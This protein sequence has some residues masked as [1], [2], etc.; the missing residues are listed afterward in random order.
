MIASMEA[1][2]TLLPLLTS[3]GDDRADTI[4]SG[5]ITLWER[6][7]PERIRGYY[8]NGSYANATATP[9]SDLDL[10]I[11]FKGRY[12][13]QAESDLAQELCESIEALHPATFVDM[14]YLTEDSLQQPDRVSIALQLKR[15]SCL[16]YGED[17]RDQISASPD[18]RYVRDTMHIPYFGSRYGR[19]QLEV[20]TFPLDYPD[21]NG[22]FYGYDGWTL[23]SADDREQP[24][25]KMLV[26]IVTRIA[27]AI[28]A[29][30]AGQYVGTKRDSV[31]LYRTHIGDE[32]TDLVEQ[33]Y[34]LCKERWQYRVPSK[35]GDREQ[36]RALCQDALRFEND[37]FAL[38]RSYLL[39]ELHNEERENQLR[40]V[41]RL[42]QII[43]PGEDIDT[44]LV[45]LVE[46]ADAE[47]RNAVVKTQQQRARATT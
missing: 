32:W 34:H 26:V 45:R 15:S 10:I 38:Y 30:R 39:E 42:G 13:D 25:T 16:I 2:M 27:T 21:P 47:L 14:G 11:L 23:P 1:S 28:V 3:T 9:T 5:V 6:L 46:R 17:I 43:Y 44:T 18:A 19:P 37:Y 35:K 40:A 20:L 31:D 36:L 24:G 8:L 12:R 7:F 29:L 41:E 33:V 4:L 22:R